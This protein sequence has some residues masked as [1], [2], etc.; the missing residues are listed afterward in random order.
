MTNLNVNYEVSSM[1]E[2]ADAMEKRAD[3]VRSRISDSMRK[4]DVANLKGQAQAWESASRM[5][6]GTAVVS[7]EKPES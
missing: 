1:D 3:E 6:R 7:D 2:L 4:R 5:V